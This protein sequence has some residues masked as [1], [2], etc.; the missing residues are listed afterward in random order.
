MINLLRAIR[1]TFA[2]AFV[3]GL[4]YPLFGCLIGWLL[5]PFSS[6][7]SLMKAGREIVGSYLIAAPYKGPEWFAPRPSAVNYNGDGS[8]GSNDAPTSPALLQEVQ[9]NMRDVLKANPSLSAQNI[10]PSMVESSASGL[11]P[12]IEFQDALDQIPRIAKATGMSE[13][14][15]RHLV[16]SHV[17]EPR[18][19]LYGVPMVNVNEL[20][21]AL[22]QARKGNGS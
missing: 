9:A 10:S 15:L 3:L 19:G 17:I 16:E 13:A 2:S 8:G 22:A 20:N 6:Q 18:L 12:D 4:L 21:H 11:D 1:F 7:G 5:F 14:W